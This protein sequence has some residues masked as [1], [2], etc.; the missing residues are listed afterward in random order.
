M[1]IEREPYWIGE[2]GV[3]AVE[4]QFNA[5]FMGAWTTKRTFSNGGWFETPVDVFYQ[6]N[7]DKAR[8]HT[9]YFGMFNRDG[10]TMICDAASAF[11]EPATGVLG[12]DD[13]VVVSRHRHD[14][15]ERF[16]DNGEYVMIDGG[17]DYVRASAGNNPMVVVRV[18]DGEFY[19]EVQPTRGMQRED[20][21]HIRAA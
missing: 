18:I 9:H 1:W 17:R 15:Q 13:E 10:K 14:Y 11:S 12:P 21:H 2:E 5:K 8:G 20:P 7:P 3:A 19:F 4:K 16:G 6:P